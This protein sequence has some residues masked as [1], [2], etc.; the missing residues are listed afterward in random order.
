MQQGGFIYCVGEKPPSSNPWSTKK[1][2]VYSA[3]EMENLQKEV[4]IYRW[5]GRA[6]FFLGKEHVRIDNINISNK[7]RI[8]EKWSI[9]F[10]VEYH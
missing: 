6:A 8:W 2:V 4:E 3:A 7:E 9:K 5:K 1:K 10:Q